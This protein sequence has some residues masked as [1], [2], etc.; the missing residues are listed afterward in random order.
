VWCRVTGSRLV[1][2]EDHYPEGGIGSAVLE[3]LADA[4]VPALQVVHLL[5][6]TCPPRG[7]RPNCS[8]RPVSPSLHDPEAA[9][10]MSRLPGNLSTD[11]VQA[12]VVFR[13]YSETYFFRHTFF[14]MP[15]RRLRLPRR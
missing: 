15:T 12:V 13:E 4:D 5:S 14:E 11:I 2:V 1:M 6:K 3:A 7:P 10:S 8:M 9:T